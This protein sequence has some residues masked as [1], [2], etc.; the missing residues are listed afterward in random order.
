VPVTSELSIP[1][2]QI[3]RSIFQVRGLKVMLDEDLTE[4]FDVPTKRLYE[5]VK[6][7]LDRF[8]DDF[9]IQLT[10]EKWDAQRRSGTL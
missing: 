1:A 8:P 2:G 4:L 10:A 9:M 3:E 6:R 7:N 5:Q